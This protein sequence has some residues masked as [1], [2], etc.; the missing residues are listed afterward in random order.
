MLKE[1][2]MQ[3]KQRL[4]SIIDSVGRTSR[5]ADDIKKDVTNDFKF[6]NLSAVRSSFALS[7]NLD[8]NTVGESEHDV[9]FLFLFTLALSKALEGKEEI[10]ISV[11][12]YFTKLEVQQWTDYKEI[13]N[14]KEDIFPYTIEEVTQLI[15]NRVWQTAM[16]SQQVNELK[17]ANILLYNFKTQR[18]PKITASGE[19]INLDVSKVNEIVERMLSG[20]QYPDP[21]ILNILNNGES[22]IS[23]NEKNKKFIIL[24][25][26][27]INIVDGFHRIVA[28][29][30]A[31]EKN[32]EL[33]FNWQI[34]LTFLTEKAAHDYMSQKDKQKPMKK[35]YIQQMDYNKP[36][37]LVVDVIVDDRLSELAKVM[38][39]DD[40]YIRLN[41]ALT[42]KSI[43]AQ[44]ISECYEEQ[45]K[46][47]TNIRSIGKW[48]VEFTDYLMGLY[49][50]EFIVNPYDVKQN[51]MINHKNMFYGYIAMSA[52]LQGN[53]DWKELLKDKMESIDF[54]N[55]NQ[56]WRDIGITNNKDANKTTRNKLYYLFKE[57]IFN[58][59]VSS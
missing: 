3:L 36:E 8:L 40:A 6:R 11:E 24:E 10:R 44:A 30:I 4:A 49:T 7:G 22:N 35:E 46:V 54:S 50:E 16:S 14:Q 59:Q 55:E 2:E 39:D 29:S 58:E 31:I 28:N 5:Y 20:E 42:K 47:S 27:V 53:K 41:R 12:D 13:D 25:G 33:V 57:G 52:S 45:L 56:T 43:V 32:P 19:K 26:S 18:N 51:S 37:N 15:S 38:K 23:Y 1:K 9:R 48:I 34:T 21:I 17:V